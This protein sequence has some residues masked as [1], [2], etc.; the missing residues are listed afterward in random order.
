MGKVIQF[1]TKNKETDSKQKAQ[2]LQNRLDEIEIENEYINK[3]LDYLTNALT[4]NLD[5]AS[6]I[7]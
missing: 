7:L 3:D 4:K 5:E 2:V 6:T 1:P